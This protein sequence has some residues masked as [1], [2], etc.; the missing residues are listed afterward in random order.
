MLYVDGY[1]TQ[2]RSWSKTKGKH[3][4]GMIVGLMVVHWLQDLVSFY[5][6]IIL[7]IQCGGDGGVD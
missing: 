2:Y 1:Q 7:E 5:Q 6:F 4:S 3:I